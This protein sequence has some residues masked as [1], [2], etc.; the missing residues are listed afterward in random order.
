MSSLHD[1]MY[2]I[3]MMNKMSPDFRNAMKTPHDF[4]FHLCYHCL[5]VRSGTL[6]LY[7]GEDDLTWEASDLYI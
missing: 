7:G 1:A 4:T 5:S 6:S 2:L 3:T